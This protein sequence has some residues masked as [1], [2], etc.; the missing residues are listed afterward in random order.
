MPPSKAYLEIRIGDPETHKSAQ[1]AHGRA[2]AF[3]TAKGAELGIEPNTRPEDMED[4]QKEVVEEAYGNDPA[5]RDKVLSDGH[6]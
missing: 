1:D 3:I 2:L 6:V 5:W 4:W